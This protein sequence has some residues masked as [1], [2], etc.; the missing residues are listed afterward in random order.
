MSLRQQ[1][2]KDFF[3]CLTVALMAVA[4]MAVTVKTPSAQAALPISQFKGLLNK[5]D[6]LLDNTRKICYPFFHITDAKPPFAKILT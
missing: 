2:R 3:I 5:N 6:H 4:I 1:G